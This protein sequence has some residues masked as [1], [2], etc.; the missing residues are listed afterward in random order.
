[1]ADLLTGKEVVG[2]LH[3]SLTQNIESLK[4][5]GVEPTLAVVRMGDRPDD[6]SYERTALKRAET[7]GVAI[8]SFVLDEQAKQEEVDE[9]IQ[10]VN[11]DTSIHGCLLFRPLPSHIDEQAVCDSIKFEK[12]IDGVSVLSLAAIFTD[13]N[14]GFAPC[15]AA[16]CMEI[17]DYY[18][19]SLEGKR[20]A[21]VGRSLVV[22]KPLAMMMLQRNATVTMCH[23]R[24][25][26]L[27]KVC[28]EADIVVCA[29]GKARAFGAS[30]FRS[31]QTVIDVGINFD[32][33]GNLCGDVDFE[34]VEPL[35]ASITP[36]PRGVG[37]VTTSV[38]MRNTVQA[39]QRTLLDT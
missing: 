12:D 24:T 26:D 14:Q 18:N 28:Q 1:M 19:I 25:A 38:L 9:I 3:E 22:G 11:A 31:G 32:A 30:F 16:A 21:V 39:A 34:T 33:E 29:V 6:L 7:L 2:R 20:V 13:A 15:T 17:L 36:V 5:W 35:V 4:E 37:S 8:K 27:E 10:K 23:S